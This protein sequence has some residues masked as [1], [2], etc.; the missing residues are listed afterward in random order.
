MEWSCPFRL[1]G[2]SH[3]YPYH[4]EVIALD[5]EGVSFYSSSFELED[6]IIDF[7]AP[8]DGILEGDFLYLRNDDLGLRKI[9]LKT[10]RE[11]ARVKKGKEEMWFGTDFALSFD[12]RLVYVLSEEKDSYYLD[13]FDALT[14]EEKGRFLL[15]CFLTSLL[16]VP[17]LK[18]TILFGDVDAFLLDEKGL[19]PLPFSIPI[20]ATLYTDDK[21]SLLYVSGGL[22]IKVYDADFKEV[23]RL[24]LISDEEEEYTPDEMLL[25]PDEM[26]KRSTKY[27]KEEILSSFLYSSHYLFLLVGEYDKT[28]SSLSLIDLRDGKPLFTIDTSFRIET[29]A[30]LHG[31]YVI[32]KAQNNCHVLEVKE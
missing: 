5:Y 19:R 22:G 21:H 14:L 25:L 23:G 6:K 28:K 8:D 24:D 2:V 29:I 32:F 18:G 3:L 30:P 31:K 20:G 11:V 1:K 9:D 16:T 12:K 13:C 17:F 7:F 10:K 27:R 15:P 26:V 4:K